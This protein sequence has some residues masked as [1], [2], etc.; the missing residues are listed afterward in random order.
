MPWREYDLSGVE[1]DEG[2]RRAAAIET[3]DRR[4]R[5][6]LD[7][8]PL[9]RA[10]LLH[11][12]PDRHRL[13]LTQHHL[14]GDGWSGPILL[15]DLLALYRHGG[16]GAALP[17]PPAFKDYLAWLQNQDQQA[18]RDAWRTYLAGIEAPTRLAPALAGTAPI[19]QAQHEELLSAEFTARLET[20]ARQ[21]AL[22][23]ATLLQGAWTVLLSR[24]TNQSDI[25]YGHVSSGR[26]ALVPGIER[27]LGLLITTTP[28]RVT[29]RPTEPVLTFLKRLQREQAALLPH[30]HLSLTEIHK[31]AGREVLFD[32][33]FTFE[34]YPVDQAHDPGTREDLPLRAVR[35]H[36]SNHYPLSFAAIPGPQLALRLHYRADLFDHASAERLAARLTRLLEQVTADPAAPLHRLDILAPEERRLLLHD[37]NDTAA[38]IPGATLVELFERQVAKTPANIALVFQG[39]ELSYA[40]LEGRSNQLAW[41]LIASGI[42][43][44][45]IV[46]IC[47]ERSP[48]MIV[49]ILGTLKAG[50]AYLPLHPDYPAERLAFMTQDARPKCLL[51]S[52]ALALADAGCGSGK[53]ISPPQLRRGPRSAPGWLEAAL[54]AVC[55]RRIFGA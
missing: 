44:E 47:L 8:A 38:A 53:S 35:G 27:M 23:L 12:G 32:T 55:N 7:Q 54:A 25:V 10:A 24:L 37:F 15:Q 20:F 33:L 11:L 51:T 30:Q 43:P 39:Q 34:N 36:N 18:A 29:L 1:P 50:A 2:D 14:L 17:P 28:A 52:S 22:T 31:L 4:G 6:R 41:K 5:F 46:A 9:I 26:Q 16:D 19:V 3:E 45:D 48:E 40:Q 42:G 49:A 21:H 13:L